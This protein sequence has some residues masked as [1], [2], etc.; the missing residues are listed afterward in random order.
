[1]Q[2]PGELKSSQGPSVVLRA[3]AGRGGKPSFAAAD[4]NGGSAQN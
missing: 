3:R 2:Q 1:M 4:A